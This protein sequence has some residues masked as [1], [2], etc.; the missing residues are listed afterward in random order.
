MF[1]AAEYVIDT[2]PLPARVLSM[3]FGSCEAA[4]GADLVHAIDGLFTQAAME[5]ISVFVSSGD[6][7]AADCANHTESPPAGQT[8]SINALC[9]SASV[10]CVG[11]TQFADTADPDAYWSRNNTTGF[12]SARGYIPEG[13]WNE[14]LDDSG[15]TQLAS[16][17][18]G[19]S[20]P[21]GRFVTDT[22][23]CRLRLSPL[24]SR[25]ASR[26][27]TGNGDRRAA[28]SRECVH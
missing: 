24:R 9:S 5:G 3:S 14:P 23:S 27:R 13:A 19:N 7:G 16:T 17:G 20:M 2:T 15:A 10:T 25:R 11:G 1:D 6:S 18:G 26:P 12:L 21:P 22:S 28:I 8:A 4:N